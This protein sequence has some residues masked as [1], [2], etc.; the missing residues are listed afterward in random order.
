MKDTIRQM[1]KVRPGDYCL[2]CGGD[3]AIIGVF[4]PNQSQLYGALAGKQRLIRYCLCEKCQKQPDTPDRAE[5]IMLAELA[6]GAHHA[7]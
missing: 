2:L 4:V 3:P 7:S 5:K 6:G 1:T